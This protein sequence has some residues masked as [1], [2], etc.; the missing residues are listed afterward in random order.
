MEKILIRKNNQKNP[1]VKRA[2]NRKRLYCISHPGPL[3]QKKGGVAAKIN[4]N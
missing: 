1:K 4:R 2:G 3:P